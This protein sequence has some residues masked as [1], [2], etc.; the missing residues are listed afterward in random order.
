MNIKELLGIS[1]S[2]KE[3]VPVLL[4]LPLFGN[5]EVYPLSLYTY[6]DST[7]F[8]AKKDGT[9][10]LFVMAENDSAEVFKSFEGETTKVESEGYFIRAVP[11][12]H[13]NA[14]KIQ[15]YFPFTKPVLLGLSNSFGYGDRIGLANPAHVRSVKGTGFKPI[16]AQ[17]SIRELT[18]TK[19]TP[20]QVMDAAIW[21]VLQEGYEE[22]FGA[23]A[24]HLKTTEDIDL[25]IRNGFTMF[26]FDPG[27]FVINEADSLDI[28]ELEKK[29]EELN[30]NVLQDNFE[31][32]SARYTDKEFVLGADFTIVPNY[33]DVLRASV[34]YCNS[35]AH[36]KTLADHL[37]NYYTTQP[38]EIEISVDE[39]ESVTTPFEHFFMASELNRL[40]VKIVSL[41]PR[42]IGD[43][44]KGI[45]YKGDLNVF[46]EEYLKHVMITEYFGSYKISLH[47]GSDKFGV[48]KV[49]GSLKRGFT[50]VKTAG[51]SYLEALKVVAVAE[52]EK[53]RKILDF[54]RNLYSK[55]KKTYHVSAELEKVKAGNEYSDKELEE[56]FVQDDA[57]QV[58]HVTFGKV[59]TEL[60][61]D[62]TPLFKTDIVDCLNENED[63]HYKFIYNHFKNHLN[64]FE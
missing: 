12:N 63:L 38:W 3:N 42:F 43:F 14:L 7:L 32:L 16:F 30:W 13:F 4:E 55:E 2:G 33:E 50:H 52:P 56:L 28:V 40:G 31:K 29:I 17:Q 19:R 35:V 61:E 45:D 37:V 9:K 6:K 26:T 36:I 10:S 23:D 20:D 15:E 18:R 25:M 49:I 46:S 5:L 47:S 27:E 57:R 41:A 53:F 48:Y 64:P 21:A 44:E 34:K 62:G 11:F 24:D 39:T 58:L 51:T 8:I 1:K 54:S 60:G 22:G 59:L